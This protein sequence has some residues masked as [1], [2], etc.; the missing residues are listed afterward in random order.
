MGQ[1]LLGFFL[2]P[3]MLPTSACVAPYYPGC[4]GFFPCALGVV[5]DTHA[6]LELYTYDK[7]VEHFLEVG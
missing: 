5:R 4:L 1:A 2:S 7:V 6:H 3:Y